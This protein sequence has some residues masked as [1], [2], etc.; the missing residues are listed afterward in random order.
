MTR[1]K[2]LDLTD[3][4]VFTAL[5]QDNFTLS[6][7]FVQCRWGFVDAL[8]DSWLTCQMVEIQVVAAL[9]VCITLFFFLCRLLSIAHSI[10]FREGIF[11]FSHIFLEVILVLLA[12]AVDVELLKPAPV[13]M[14]AHLPSAH[15]ATDIFALVKIIIK[16][17]VF[18]AV[19]ALL[20]FQAEILRSFHFRGL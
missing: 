17:I 2:F 15:L 5:L 20:V 11:V 10:L 7:A 6:Q 1:G 16:I 18:K 3:G 4:D 9:L 19:L 8:L 14:H 12:L 13:D